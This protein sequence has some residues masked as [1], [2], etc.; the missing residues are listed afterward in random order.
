MSL[1]NDELV[2][3]ASPHQ[4][5]S[6]EDIELLGL[7]LFKHESGERVGWIAAL[8]NC[9]VALSL[10]RDQPA[11]QRSRVVPARLIEMRNGK[12]ARLRAFA[13]VSVALAI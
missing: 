7:S 2:A 9:F 4:S 6:C 12:L 5:S 10:H 11:K 8:A 1:V 13:R 3:H